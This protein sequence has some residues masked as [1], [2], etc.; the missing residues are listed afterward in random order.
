MAVTAAAVAAFLR[1][2]ADGALQAFLRSE[3]EPAAGGSGGGGV[4]VVVGSSL[5]REAVRAGRWVFLQAYAP[6]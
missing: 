1:A 5:E 2:Y 3:E 6:W 4:R